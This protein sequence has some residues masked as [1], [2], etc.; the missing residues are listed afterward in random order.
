L[1]GVD[2]RYEKKKKIYVERE[3]CRVRKEEKKKIE[4]KKKIIKRGQSCPY[5]FWPFVGP[6]LVFGLCG[7][8]SNPGPF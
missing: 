1:C 2:A 7:I 5:C 4:K 3:R 6:L 8:V